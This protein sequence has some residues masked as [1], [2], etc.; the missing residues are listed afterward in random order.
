MIGHPL[1]DVLDSSALGL[2][3]EAPT[4]I[5]VSDAQGRPYFV[6]QEAQEL[7]GRGAEPTVAVE[8]LSAVYQLY[9]T[10]TD[11]L[12]PTEQLPVVTA[13][14][15][16]ACWVDDL[17][18][19]RPDKTVQ[20]EVSAKPV[21][22]ADGQLCY[23]IQSF[24]DATERRNADA[25]RSLAESLARAII[26]APSF[27]DAVRTSLDQICELTGWTFGQAWLPDA[28]G[29]DLR[30]HSAWYVDRPGL[31]EFHEACRGVVLPA[32]CGLPGRVWQAKQP[33]WLAD[34]A[35]DPYRPA[36]SEAM[37]AFPDGLRASV[38][39]PVLADGDVVAVLEFF[40]LARGEQDQR[41]LDRVAAVAVQ[42]GIWMSTK[43]TEDAVRRSEEQF[44]KIAETAADAIIST[45]SDRRIT[46]LNPAARMLFG[47]TAEEAIGRP[48]SQ[49]VHAESAPVSAADLG[50]LGQ[51]G[52]MGA[53]ARLVAVRKDGREFPV[54]LTMTSWQR[55]PEVFFTTII[56]NCSERVE[57]EQR[58]QGALELERQAVERL[59]TL[60]LVKE[61]VLQ[62][63]SHDLRNPI[64]A[65]LTLTRML[66]ADVDGER[67][68]P[69]ESR[70]TML[71]NVERSARKMERLLQDLIDSDPLHDM[72]ARRRR[73]DIGEL[74]T[75]ALQESDLATTRP[76]HTH[77]ESVVVGIDA[78]QVDRI[79]ENLLSNAAQHLAVGVPVWVGT[80][81]AGNGVL[82][83][84]EDA[85]A[86]VP[87]DMTEQVFE[88]FRR[89]DGLTSIGLGLGLSLVARFAQLHGGRAWVEGRVGGGA[90]FRV[91]LP[92]NEAVP[93]DA[94]S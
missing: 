77:I 16:V 92:D 45:S 25:E 37:A 80:V 52:L 66:R 51:G 94:P 4:A 39:I 29:Q 60:D 33:E 81:Q 43:R 50:S 21:F 57:Y 48:L 82:I 7:L 73:C 12:Y 53:P 56:R 79:V 31:K 42:V 23:V 26:T 71:T 89:G 75:R 19:R 87:A 2:L 40:V 47:Y 38:A 83:S 69:L 20:A 34:A 46:F 18:I 24:L 54:E 72:Q 91:Y 22:G 27:A 70:A 58:L 1:T 17:E 36:A 90:S 67:L 64:A 30:C 84:V 28:T 78:G 55:G 85:G 10:G 65:V 88:P 63:V 15:G 8:Q 41:A 6:N 68:L 3:D 14:T 61:T 49:L 62:T 86:G 9:V 35:V 93:Y 59:R 11:L 76:V 32:G 74:V 5:F 44:R 13:L